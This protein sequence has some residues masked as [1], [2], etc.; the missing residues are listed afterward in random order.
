MHE[1]FNLYKLGEFPPQ[2]RPETWPVQYEATNTKHAKATKSTT[3]SDV[4]GSG[5]EE[6]EAGKGTTK[7]KGGGKKGKKAR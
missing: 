3:K 4:E 1:N 5:E 7:G 6:P 2:T